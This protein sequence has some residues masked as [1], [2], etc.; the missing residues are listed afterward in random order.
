MEY[1]HGWV[2]DAEAQAW[3]NQ[4]YEELWVREG[5]DGWFW[6]HAGYGLYGQVAYAELTFAMRDAHFEF[7]P[8]VL[9][10]FSARHLVVVEGEL[11]YAAHRTHWNGRTQFLG[12]LAVPRGLDL[13]LV[14]FDEAADQVHHGPQ[15]TALSGLLRKRTWVTEGREHA[16]LEFVVKPESR[17]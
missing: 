13:R 17:D 8:P 2:W 15:Y 4:N 11:L 16:C 12:Y 3:H 5:P 7:S 10:D 14:A 6:T 9:H 1:K